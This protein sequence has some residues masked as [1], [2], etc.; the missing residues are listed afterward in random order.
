MQFEELYGRRQR[1]ELTMATAAE[2]LRVPSGRFIAGVGTMTPTGP[3]GW[4]IGGSPVHRGGLAPRGLNIP[5][6]VR[7]G[8]ARLHAPVFPH[9]PVGRRISDSELLYVEDAAEGILLAAGH[10]NGSLPVN[11]ESGEEVSIR[12]G[13]WMSTGPK[14]SSDF[15]PV[16]PCAKVSKNPLDGSMPTVNRCRSSLLAGSET[17]RSRRPMTSRKSAAKGGEIN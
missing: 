13:A 6:Q 5:C 17:F 1:R 15:K 8:R 9:S 4:R 10:N 3:R 11:L 2:M 12:G 14:S 7:L 16:I